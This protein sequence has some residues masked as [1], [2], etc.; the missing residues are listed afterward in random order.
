MVYII[1]VVA[2]GGFSQLFDQLQ[3]FSLLPHRI[4]QLVRDALDWL[5]Q[6]IH[7]DPTCSVV[8]C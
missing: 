8:V 3:N 7:P 4:L 6:C 5:M 1:F 2:L